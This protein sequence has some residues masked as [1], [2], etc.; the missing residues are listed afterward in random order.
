[1]LVVVAVVAALQLHLHLHL[2][3]DSEDVLAQLELATMPS[4]D[5]ETTVVYC[6]GL[7]DLA[8]K[9][10]DQIDLMNVCSAASFTQDLEEFAK[11]VQMNKPYYLPNPELDSLVGKI[12]LINILQ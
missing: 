7:I 11:T 5:G 3:H 10:R 4:R 9:A 12:R 2:H 8:L 6:G 1:V